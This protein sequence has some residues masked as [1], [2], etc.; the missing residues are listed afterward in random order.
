M[1]QEYLIDTNTAIDYMGE[2]LPVQALDFL[3]SII[4]R[5]YYLSI[6]NKIELL[7]FKGISEEEEQPFLKFIDNADMILL[8][9]SIIDKTIALRK[10]YSVKLP[11]AIIAASA[12]A[13][14]ATLITRRILGISLYLTLTR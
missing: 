9:D 3:D 2:K 14:K 6:I 12:M 11:D 7:G 1:E 13:V 8:N 4:D 10:T 5:Q